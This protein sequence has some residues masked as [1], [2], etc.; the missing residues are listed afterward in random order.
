MKKGNKPVKKL[1][2]PMKKTNKN[3]GKAKQNLK[4]KLKST[5][6]ND[7]PQNKELDNF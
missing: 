6:E 5:S 4:T 2:Q 3:N 1:P 7:M